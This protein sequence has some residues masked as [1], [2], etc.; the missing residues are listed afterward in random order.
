[1]ICSYW[2]SLSRH[3]D[4]QKIH[5]KYRCWWLF[6]KIKQMLKWKLGFLYL[7]IEFKVT[8]DY[9]LISSLHNEHSCNMFFAKLN[10]L[11]GSFSITKKTQTTWYNLALP[12]SNK[13]KHPRCWLWSFFVGAGSNDWM[14]GG[15][16]SWHH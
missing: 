1:M 12:D 16:L 11:F 5:K 9:V 14:V 13:I 8:N 10:A 7:S 3:H 6:D 15:V 4:W 2:C